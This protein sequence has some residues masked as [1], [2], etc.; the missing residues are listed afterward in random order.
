MDS[1]VDRLT[2]ELQEKL[3]KSEEELKPVLLMDDSKFQ[4]YLDEQ[5]KKIDNWKANAVAALQKQTENVV[6]KMNAGFFIFLFGLCLSAFM[7]DLKL[8]YFLTNY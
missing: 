1:F 3:G 5:S 4:E 8:L 7:N 2:S 6:S